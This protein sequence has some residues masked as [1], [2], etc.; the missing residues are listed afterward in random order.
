MALPEQ[1][2]VTKYWL[3]MPAKA[4]L[5]VYAVHVT[6]EEEEEFEATLPAVMTDTF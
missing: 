5:L 6:L 3:F 2:P 4:S 1:K